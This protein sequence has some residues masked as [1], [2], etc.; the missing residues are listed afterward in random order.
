LLLRSSYFISG[1]R[2]NVSDGALISVGWLHLELAWKNGPEHAGGKGSQVQ[3]LSSLRSMTRGL[4]FEVD[5][6]VLFLPDCGRKVVA[7]RRFGFF[8]CRLDCLHR[9]RAPGRRR[10]STTP[11][12]F[13]SDATRVGPRCHRTTCGVATASSTNRPACSSCRTINDN[14]DRSYAVRPV[15][16]RQNQK[17]GDLLGRFT[18]NDHSGEEDP[19]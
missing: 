15:L 5:P 11:R 8:Q 3:I 19:V 9:I 1:W 16:N 4:P 10:R 7:L 17:A 13:R 2:G 14:T 6:L 18:A 12:L